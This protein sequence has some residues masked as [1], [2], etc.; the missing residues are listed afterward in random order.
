[1]NKMISFSL[2]Q[3]WKTVMTGLEITGDHHCGGEV[4]QKIFSIRLRIIWR[5]SPPKWWSLVIS[6][7]GCRAWN[8]WWSSQW[9][10]DVFRL[11]SVIRLK[12][13]WKISPPQWWWPVIS[14]PGWFVYISFSLVLL[15][16]TRTF[17]VLIR[18]ILWFYLY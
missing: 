10:R 13:I 4:F 6:S 3:C 5:I 15:I 14:R 1:M 8:N 12:I 11:F 17:Y 7:P 9:R 16:F 2:N 18:R